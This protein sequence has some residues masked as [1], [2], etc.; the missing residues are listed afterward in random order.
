[1]VQ[2]RFEL[3]H[4]RAIFLFNLLKCVYWVNISA[5]RKIILASASPR[6]RDILSIT[7][8]K[9]TVCASDYEEVIRPRLNPRDIAR[10]LSRKKAEAVAHRY[11]DSIIIAADTF[12]IFRGKLLGKPHTSPEARKM[13]TLLNGKS[14]SVITGFSIFDTGTGRKVSRSVE[15]KVWFMKMAAREIDAYVATKEPLDKAGAYAI[16]GLGAVFIE[17]IEGDFFNIMGLPLC[18]LADSLKKFGIQVLKQR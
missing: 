8:L 15:T 1:M 4:F 16:Q 17:K 6:R 14:H 18:A 12:I 11:K 5:V 10:S 3:P 7:G 2:G 9:F 13:L